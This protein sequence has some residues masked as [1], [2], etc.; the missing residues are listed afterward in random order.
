MQTFSLPTS[1]AALAGAGWTDISPYY[2]ELATAPL[3]RENV[4]EWLKSW[5][6]LEELIDEAG[7]LAMIDYKGDKAV[8]KVIAPAK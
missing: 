3:S 2:E 4:E 5:S 8:E 7:T 6:Q 1:P